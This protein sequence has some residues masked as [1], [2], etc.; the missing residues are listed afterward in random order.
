MNKQERI[1]MVRAMET[2]ARSINDEDVFEG[3]LMC[4]VADGDIDETTTDA[5]LEYY[6]EDDKYSELMETFLNVM[7]K[8]KRSGG[9]YSDDVLS[10]YKGWQK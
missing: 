3:W 8:A 1:Q 9:L 6:I 7:S 10:N 2:I 4:G 5:E